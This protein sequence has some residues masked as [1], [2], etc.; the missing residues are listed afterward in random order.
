MRWVILYVFVAIALT[1]CKKEIKEIPTSNEPVFTID[2]TIDSQ[3]I[4]LSV[5]ENTNSFYTSEEYVNGVKFFNGR[6]V[7]TDFELEIGLFDGNL[8]QASNA[9]EDLVNVAQLSFL[10]S[11]ENVLFYATKY[12]FN[13]PQ[14]IT[15]IDWYVD[16]E[17]YS[18]NTISIKKPG[19]YNICAHLT[20]SNSSNKT[21]C[22][23]V[24]LGYKRNAIFSLEYQLGQDNMLDAW[25]YEGNVPVQSIT[26]FVDG[27]Y[28]SNDFIL[29]KELNQEIYEIKANIVF[30]N[31]IERSRSILV[32]GNKDQNSVIDFAFLE[33]LNNLSCDYNV[34]IS[35]KKDGQLF[36]SDLADNTTG[37]FELI[38][39]TYLGK[40]NLSNDVF[41][42]EANVQANLKSNSTTNSKPINLK[43][44]WG[45]VLK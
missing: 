4:N 8:D 32:D 17:F 45:L 41:K 12:F 35:Y 1:A 43:I 14:N 3:A 24:I 37:K 15:S 26:W 30:Q 10:K 2:G 20:Y 13:N 39:L 36:S 44:S 34:K 27:V 18:S 28:E 6:F 38:S 33:N 19:T 22:N 16:N 42:I 23:E 31:G 21:I 11:S 25:I 5:D 7:G 40:D 29:H 9:I